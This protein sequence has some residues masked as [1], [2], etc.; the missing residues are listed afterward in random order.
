[1]NWEEIIQEEHDVQPGDNPTHYTND[2][3]KGFASRGRRGSAADKQPESG[4]QAGRVDDLNVASTA[5]PF[6]SFD[7][8]SK[9][10]VDAR[11]SVD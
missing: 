9:S 11:G 8:V 4:R 10:G 7:R 1:M 5:K 6:T 3:F 2:I